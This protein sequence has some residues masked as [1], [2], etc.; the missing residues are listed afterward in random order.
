MRRIGTIFALILAAAFIAFPVW[1]G[2]AYKGKIYNNI[3]VSGFNVGGLTLSQ[4]RNR[5]RR[6]PP[7]PQ[8]ITITAESF[9]ERLDI[10]SL[11][12]S[13]RL[14]KALMRAYGAGRD[15]S[16]YA[17]LPSAAARAVNPQNIQIEYRLNEAKLLK[18]LEEIGVLLNRPA[19]NAK[20]LTSGGNITIEPHQVGRT[21]LVDSSA[22]NIRASL[23]RNG[24][25]AA[26]AFKLD[27]PGTTA[28]SL[29]VQKIEVMIA[30]FSTDFDPKQEG[31]NTNIVLA[32]KK[33][34]GHLVHPGDV[35][36]FNDVVGARTADRGYKLATVIENGN[37]AQGIGGGICQLATT[38]YNAYMIAG[39][40]TVERNLHSNFIAAYPL[41]RDAGVS[42][43]TYDLRF[44][45]D[46]GGYIL[47]RALTGHGRMTIRLYGPRIERVNTFSKPSST[48]FVP[49]RIRITA[50]KLPP[51]VKIVAQKGVSGRTVR[52]KRTVEANGKVLFEEMINSRYT[53]RDEIIKAGPE[54]NADSVSQER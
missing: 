20:R 27:T 21:L 7:P 42:D 52:L 51:G 41:G 13:A 16:F 30:Q 18:L 45:N 38:V 4:A 33:I 11:G 28:E 43:G 6:L 53:P 26:L 15:D 34:D 9:S 5:L 50:E 40:P 25:R 32:A 19:I 24:R 14:S 47:M 36:S 39:L 22:K 54:E 46:T 1:Q 37:L 3:S 29:R 8:N 17:Q 12:A 31:R 2:Y 23:G 49:Y 10:N 35:F 48:D 44:K